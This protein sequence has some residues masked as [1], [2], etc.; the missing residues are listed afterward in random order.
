MPPFLSPHDRPSPP[1][2][3]SPRAVTA[4]LVPQVEVSLGLQESSEEEE[5]Q[6]KFPEMSELEEKL[7][8]RSRRR[9]S[10]FKT[11]LG[12]IQLTA[13][14]V[15]NFVVPWHV[16]GSSAQGRPAWVGPPPPP[17]LS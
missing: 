8:T 9:W 17:P 1:S 6:L 15:H 10:Y 7:V 5:E 3:D 16:E 2:L 13:S 11:L 12:Y 14:M 4:G